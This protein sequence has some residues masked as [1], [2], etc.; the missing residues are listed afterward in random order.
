MRSRTLAVARTQPSVALVR[1]SCSIAR[2]VGVPPITAAAEPSRAATFLAP[3]R[4]SAPCTSMSG[5]MPGCSRRNT[6]RIA[7][8][9]NTSE[10]LDCSPDIT[11][12]GSSTGTRSG[13]T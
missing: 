1:Y 4:L 3:S 7:V 10:V 9:P 12:L 13:S 2:E 5:L 6:F 11:R 8:S